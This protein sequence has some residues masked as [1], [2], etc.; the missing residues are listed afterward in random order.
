MGKIGEALGGGLGQFGGSL[1]GNEGFGRDVGK[2]LGS[3]LPFKEG[4]SIPPTHSKHIKSKRAS[5]MNMG[6][7]HYASGGYVDMGHDRH[8]G[9]GLIDSSHA[10]NYHLMPIGADGAPKHA[11]QK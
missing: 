11:Y 7:Q 6:G 1:L 9:S 2:W 8:L 3:W 4:G 10:V 5:M